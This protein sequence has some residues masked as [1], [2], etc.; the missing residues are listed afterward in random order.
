MGKGTIVSDD[1]AGLYTV[2]L[3]LD[4][5]HITAELARLAIAIPVCAALIL[6]KAAEIT[7]LEAEIA[8]L[9]PFSEE[10]KTKFRELSKKNK[11]K[12]ILTLKK[13]S[14]EVRQAYLNANTPVD[15][16]VQ[17]WCADK[18]TGL[19]G[20]VGIIE[21]P[22][23]R[24]TT[25][26]IKPGYGG[27]AVYNS[28]RDGQLQ[29]S[30]A[31][32]SNNIF[33]NWAMLP[34]WQKWF[35]A[36]RYGTITAVD[37]DTC[38]I[39]LEQATS[40][41][42]DEYGNPLD[43]NAVTTLSNV[44]IVYMDVNGAAFTVGDVVLIKFVSTKAD[45]RGGN[46]WAHATV[47]GFKDHPKY[48]ES[49]ALI[50]TEVYDSSWNQKGF[51]ELD[52][53]PE[54]VLTLEPSI[55]YPTAYIDEIVYS[56]VNSG[57]V[58]DSHGDPY[59]YASYP[60]SPS[61]G[62]TQW[63]F[64]MEAVEHETVSETLKINGNTIKTTQWGIVHPDVVRQLILNAPTEE[65]EPH[66]T[67]GNFYP[68][69]R[70]YVLTDTGWY[71]TGTQF[72]M[73]SP[74]A[75]YIDINH[76]IYIRQ[77]KIYTGVE[78]NGTQKSYLVINGI[79]TPLYENTISDDGYFYNMYGYI[80]TGEGDYSEGAA[81]F[82]DGDN[83][84]YIASV[85]FNSYDPVL[86]ESPFWE[87]FHSDGTTLKRNTFTINTDDGTLALLGNIDGTDIYTCGDIT[88]KE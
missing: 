46:N 10:Y 19:S 39:T 87:F 44:P 29:P 4:I 30:I 86:V 65:G 57:R 50:Y 80:L 11:E 51:V 83:Y 2:T 74:N 12:N 70:G 7:A 13:T 33:Y 14:C 84:R 28:T 67:W 3:N 9:D 5:T 40:S 76:Y 53:D 1:G 18:T 62:T 42:T 25:V 41:V 16:E 35:P 88:I 66:I 15:P 27:N 61:P 23:E 47:I 73:W 45:V 55:S 63:V 72:D 68:P 79:E 60:D 64:R 26:N 24:K 59:L 31:G 77:D 32:L 58:Y 54:P 20:T 49:G 69:G 22:G 81:I 82:Q 6:T 75:G 71:Y 38:N 52:S 17:A 37:G 78:N 36:Y 43:V 85:A 21:I 56:S 34:G 48:P 8:S